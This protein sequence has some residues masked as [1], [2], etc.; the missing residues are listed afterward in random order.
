MQQTCPTPPLGLGQDILPYVMGVVPASRYQIAHLSGLRLVCR[1][2]KAAVD[3]CRQNREWMGRF[4]VQAADFRDDVA[5][6]GNVHPP[7]TLN[8]GIER[9]LF[10]KQWQPLIEGMREYNSDGT[11]QE[12]IITRWMQTLSGSTIFDFSMQFAQR[13]DAS[14]LNKFGLHGVVAWAMRTHPHNRA[15]Q[16]HGCHLLFLIVNDMDELHVTPYI[17]A[18][19]AAVMHANMQ[20][21]ELQRACV[22]V[23]EKMLRQVPDFF[24]D[25]EYA[26]DSDGED[27]PMSDVDS[28]S[29]WVIDMSA[30]IQTGVHNVPNLLVRAMREHLDDHDFQ[31]D[32][33][34]VFYLLVRIMNGLT[35]RVCTNDFVM[36]EAETVL[37][38]SMRRHSHR[39]RPE[40]SHSVQNNCQCALQ[41]LM[42]FDFSSMKH[43]RE[44]MQASI[45]AAMQYGGEFMEHMAIM[46]FKIMEK[47]AT[48]P[49]ETERMQ[50]FAANSGMVQMYIRYILEHAQTAPISEDDTRDAFQLLIW[51]CINNADTSA[52]MVQADVVRTIDSASQIT[53]KTTRWHKTRDMLVE[54]LEER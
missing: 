18:T 36:H 15:V 8:R 33:S 43:V 37:I 7:L 22:K 39:K 17:V 53:P 27:G 41:G 31:Q 28:D 51:I 50:T 23:L 16:I 26:P 38:A 40:M 42:D 9:M 32:A 45:N 20:D 25:G 49:L 5:R 24:S 21:L 6:T 54:I 10:A 52:Q 11:T 2:F 29:R 30:L 35:N 4:A 12:I 44:A 1:D 34:D 46:F 47:L 13:D 19:L 48:A 14:A 3:S